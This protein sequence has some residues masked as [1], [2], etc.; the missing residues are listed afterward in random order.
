MDILAYNREMWNAQV[1]KGNRWTCPVDAET[2]AAAK[3]NEW[4]VVLTPTK[5]VPREWFPN[6]AGLDVLCLASGG[7]Q[8]APILAAAGARVTL[9][10]NSPAQLA[11]D[12]LVA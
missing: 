7:G 12:R 10:D 3:R 4:H 11:Q 9:L 1:A 8:Q 6:L 2:I 5:P